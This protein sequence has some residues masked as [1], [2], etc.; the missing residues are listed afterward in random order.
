[1]WC[2][3][4][5]GERTLVPMSVHTP[6]DGGRERPGCRLLGDV[7]VTE[8][9]GQGGDRPRPL[10][11]VGLGDRL[12]DVDDAHSRRNGRTSTFRLQCFDPSAASLSAT[13]RSGASMIQ[14]P[15]RYFSFP[16]WVGLGYTAGTGR[17]SSSA[18]PRSRASGRPYRFVMRAAGGP[19]D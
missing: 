6:P 5:H 17:S 4:I 1:V 11:V 7:E 8:T 10:L 15:P 2:V 16:T 12:P 13:S 9:P 14:K 18:A 19:V 3:K